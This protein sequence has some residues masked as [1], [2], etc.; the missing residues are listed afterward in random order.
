MG[1]PTT[2]NEKIADIICEALAKGAALYK[3]CQEEGMPDEKTVYRW[4]EKHEEFS[5]KY[6]RARE[7]QQDYEAD[8][9]IA[10][11]DNATDANIAR[12]QIDARKWRASKLAP[13]KYGDKLDVEHAGTF[14]FKTVSY[15]D[16]EDDA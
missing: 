4:L 5:Q 14:T 15:K 10:I 2:Y 11:A 13:K 3:L 9:I 16:V 12:L 8:H 7:R 6:T 1:R